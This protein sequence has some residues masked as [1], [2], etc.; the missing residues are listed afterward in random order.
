[1]L[2]TFVI[3]IAIVFIYVWYKSTLKVQDF[4]E[5]MNIVLQVFD[6]RPKTILPPDF[7]INQVQAY[8]SKD[9]KLKYDAMSDDE[10]TTKAALAQLC[11]YDKEPFKGKK[12][13]YSSI[14]IISCLAN[15]NLQ[16]TTFL[17]AVNISLSNLMKACWGYKLE[18]AYLGW[19][20]F[21]D[22]ITINGTPNFSLIYK[23]DNIIVSIYLNKFLML[24]E[25]GFIIEKFEF[26][27]VKDFSPEDYYIIEYEFVIIK[28]DNY[29][30]IIEK[31][32]VFL[33]K[34]KETKT[35]GV[36]SLSKFE[37]LQEYLDFKSVVVKIRCWERNGYLKL[38]SDIYNNYSWRILEGKTYRM[39]KI[40]HC[41]FAIP[42]KI[43][44]ELP[45]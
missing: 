43:S 26:A 9:V 44:S 23:F 17:N 5:I 3:L 24:T 45:P 1:M 36:L 29:D 30:I 7:L 16:G 11:G 2:V 15:M 21:Y 32:G 6:K 33:R 4:S 41:V 38:Y 22:S 18:N 35:Y 40:N 10:I 13:K 8:F 31:K 39:F 25:D 27:N 20:T 37:N 28:T 42:L 34:N 19:E 12:L 14:K